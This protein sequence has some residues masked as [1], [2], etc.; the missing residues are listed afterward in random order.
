[1]LRFSTLPPLSLY[2]HLPWCVRKCPYCDFNSYES[3]A[4]IP[5]DAYVD[6]LLEDLDDELPF[7]HGRPLQSIFIGGGTPS[8]FSGAAIAR[9]LTGIGERIKITAAAEITLEANPGTAEAGRFATYRKAGVNRL[10]IGVQS[11]RDPQ[12]ARLGRI[13]GCVEAVKACEMART[14]GFRTINLDLMYG[15]PDDDVAGA[16]SDLRAAIALEPPHLSWYQLT[17]E[18][19]TA[20]HHA[21]PR[22]PD[23]DTI[24][25]T[26]SAGRT[27]LAAHGYERYE[28]SAYAHEGVH[29]LHNLNYWQ[30][31]DYLGIG[32]GAHGKITEPDL[33]RIL[34][35]VKQRKPRTYLRTA[36]T[37]AGVSTETVTD[38]AQVRVEFMMNALRL[39]E[40]VPVAWF[41]QR[42]GLTLDAVEMAWSRAI[43][44]GWM[45]GERRRIRPTVMGQQFLNSLVDLFL[46][47]VS[48]VA[49]RAG[50]CPSSMIA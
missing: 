48:G 5:E 30:F 23:E 21:P 18:P 16:L 1:M 20:F 25:E 10:S 3:I 47:D 22:L 14:A 6:A 29:C 9:L 28:V 36:G 15:L 31:G 45:C 13:H 39:T 38:P 7:A 26:E 35:R 27:L 49:P 32:A 11:F 4:G 17:L 42:T 50:S 44:L 37:E 19:N 40:G 46:E 8:L 24:L 43:E 33:G 2:V 41:A 34:R 12:L